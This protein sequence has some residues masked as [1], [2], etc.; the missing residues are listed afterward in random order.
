M[1]DLDRALYNEI[2]EGLTLNR[3]LEIYYNSYTYGV[4]TLEERWQLWRDNELLAEDVDFI[5]L[6]EEPFI[7]GK[8]LKEIIERH[9]CGLLLM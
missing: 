3:E 6:L 5:S 4:V 8:S 2:I 1:S 7:N 9:E